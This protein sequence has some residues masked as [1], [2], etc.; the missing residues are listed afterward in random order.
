MLQ[1]PV[2]TVIRI[3]GEFYPAEDYHQNYYKK[4]KLRYH[5]YRFRCGRDQR[6]EDLWGEKTDR[7]KIFKKTSKYKIPGRDELKKKQILE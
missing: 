1:E 5:Y 4:N 2:K 3:A 6:L 7:I